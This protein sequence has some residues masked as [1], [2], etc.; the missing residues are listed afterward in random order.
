MLGLRHK[1]QPFF[2]TVKLGGQPTLTARTMYRA[3]RLPVGF[4]HGTV[5][6]LADNWVAAIG[7]S[8][9]GIG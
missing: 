3:A 6:I 1:P 2:L 9:G 5:S 4:A 7:A 8:L